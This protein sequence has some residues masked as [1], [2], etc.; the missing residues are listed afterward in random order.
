MNNSRHNFVDH[1]PCPYA[2]S[3]FFTTI[4][5]M[6]SLA[7]VI[8]NLL[9]LVAVYKTPILR[10]RT[11]FYYANM[12]VSDFLSSIATW[13]LYL[14]DEI[15]TSRGSLIQ[16]SQATAG[17][18]VG[19]YVRMLSTSVSILSLVLIAVD[20]F[21]ATVFPLKA[22]LLTCKIR[23]AM[24]FATWS[25]SIGYC[26][27]M[28]YFSK[29]EDIGNETFCRFAWNDTFALI[30][31]YI[32]GISMINIAPLIAIVILYSRI[33][34]V[35]RRNPEYGTESGN[36]ELRRLK[37]GQNVM[38]I[39]KSIVILYFVSFF[40]FCVFFDFEDNLPDSFCQG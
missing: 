38:R 25:I 10:T 11:N 2:V 34:R 26:F 8:G 4:L 31:Y 29:V 16:G 27:P 37:Q 9:V 33:M 35:L 22:S 20:R 6:I 3:V 40:L 17:C 21:I 32:T 7:A 39:F 23:V 12:A 1:V 15:I 28:L 30:T 13:P 18:K 24:L 36:S 19:V 5:A 14:T